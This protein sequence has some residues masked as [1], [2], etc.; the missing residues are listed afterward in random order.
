MNKKIIVFTLIAALLVFS[1][2]AINYYYPLLNNDRPVTTTTTYVLS[3][4]DDYGNLITRV[5]TTDSDER[6]SPYDRV[7]E[8]RI[9]VYKDKIVIDLPN[10]QWARFTDTNSMDPVLDIGTNAIEIVPQQP[11]DLHVGDIVSY[12]SKYADGTIIHRIIEIGHDDSGWYALMKGDNNQRTD[13]G[14]IRFSQIRRVV[15]A[16]IY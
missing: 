12:E 14:K 11:E 1:A 6:P 8:D 2:L 3:G 7:T 5:I 10:A 4:D 9:H 13:P 15:V 16:L